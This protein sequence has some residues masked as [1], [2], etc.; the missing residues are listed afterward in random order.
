MKLSKQQMLANIDETVYSI[1]L[2]VV[3]NSG[4]EKNDKEK[5]VCEWRGECACMCVNKSQ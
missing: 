3:I 1:S 4:D 5:Q 2:S